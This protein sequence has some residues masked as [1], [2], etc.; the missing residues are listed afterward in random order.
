MLY[1]DSSEMTE[2]LSL[3]CIVLGI[4]TGSMILTREDIVGENDETL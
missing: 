4:V 2:E 1:F 3:I